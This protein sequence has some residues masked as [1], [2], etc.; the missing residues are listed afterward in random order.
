MYDLSEYRQVSS[1]EVH[2]RPSGMAFAHRSRNPALRFID[3]FKRSVLG[4]VKQRPSR[5]D[6]APN[7]GD[8]QA[9]AAAPNEVR[10][11]VLGWFT[12]AI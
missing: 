10:R 9:F 7:A 4:C 2:N 5:A 1:F 11:R 12:D 6:P 8:T 3:A